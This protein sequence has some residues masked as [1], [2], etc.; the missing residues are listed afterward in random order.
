MSKVID[1]GFLKGFP[2]DVVVDEEAKT[3]TARVYDLDCC[4]E[5]YVFEEATVTCHEGDEFIE[6]KGIH[7]AKLKLMK[8]LY[9]NKKTNAV[10]TIAFLQKELRKFRKMRDVS[11][12]KL[13][14]IKDALE[15]EFYR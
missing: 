3:V 1:L 5:P 12:R 6:S 8:K 15:D 7:I 14:N 2:L 4:G 9:G 10:N 11:S 13:Q